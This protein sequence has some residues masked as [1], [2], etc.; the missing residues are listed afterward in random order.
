MVFNLKASSPGINLFTQSYFPERR[1]APYLAL[2]NHR[3]TASNGDDTEGVDLICAVDRSSAL[4]IIMVSAVPRQLSRILCTI[5][6][7][8][9]FLR[10]Y[11]LRERDLQ[12][13]VSKPTVHYWAKKIVILF[14]KIHAI[15][16]KLNVLKFV[17][18]CKS[19]KYHRVKLRY[20][21]KDRNF[22]V[23]L[24]IRELNCTHLVVTIVKSRLLAS[25]FDFKC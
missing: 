3:G 25:N 20:S 15:M 4:L 22:F 17:I 21:L 14:W 2:A 6:A 13:T 8:V 23:V 24:Y 7:F 11:F 16:M 5:L 10:R 9:S 18:F 19:E 12:P 1:W